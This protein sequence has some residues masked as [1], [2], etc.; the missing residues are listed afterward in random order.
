MTLNEHDVVRPLAAVTVNV[1]VVTPAGNIEPLARPPVN[2]VDE[3][4]QLSGV[5]NVTRAAH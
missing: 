2:A 5:E 1:F 4:G 3:P